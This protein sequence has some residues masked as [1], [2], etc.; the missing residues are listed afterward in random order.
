MVSDSSDPPVISGQLGLPV[1]MP[2][3]IPLN[4]GKVGGHLIV[5]VLFLLFLR[6]NPRQRAGKPRLFFGD[7]L[8]LI[9]LFLDI[10][11]GSLDPFLRR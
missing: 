3:D 11:L 2:A 6:T 10:L 1:L 5:F 8:K 9:F 7:S 4:P